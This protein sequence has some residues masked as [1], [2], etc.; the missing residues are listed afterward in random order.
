MLRDEP[1]FLVHLFFAEVHNSNCSKMTS[2]VVLR[3]VRNSHALNPLGEN[4]CSFFAAWKGETLFRGCNKWMK[5]LVLNELFWQSVLLFLT[6][7]KGLQSNSGPVPV[8]FCLLAS[9]RSDIAKR[10]SEKNHHHHQATAVNC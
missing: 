3:W 8:C 9:R 4:P 2:V 7:Q 1:M 5:A 10:L 6:R